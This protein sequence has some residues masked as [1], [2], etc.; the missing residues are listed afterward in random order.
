MVHQNL[1]NCF[2][3]CLYRLFKF[4][5]DFI[6]EDVVDEEKSLSEFIAKLQAYDLFTL[7]SRLYFKLLTFAHGIK[8]NKY[9]PIEL[10]SN[11]NLDKI[12]SETVNGGYRIP[13][14]DYINLRNGKK[15][16]QTI[17]EPK[18]ETLT[19]LNTFFLGC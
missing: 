13:E 2:D 10:K 8:S 5:P 17:P 7:Q 18:F 19:F 4:K 14:E 15:T 1:N 12:P 9:S 6:T 3:L 11:L 16:R